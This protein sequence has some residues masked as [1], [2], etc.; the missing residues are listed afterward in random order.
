MR[1]THRLLF[2]AYRSPIS[3]VA[4]GIVGRHS[5]QTHYRKVQVS[6]SAHPSPSMCQMFIRTI[7]SLYL[8]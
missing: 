5:I 8:C 2:A 3:A 7:F 6:S 4:A 1:A